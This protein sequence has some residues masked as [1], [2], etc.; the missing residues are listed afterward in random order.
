MRK[1]YSVPGV[2]TREQRKLIASTIRPERRALGMTQL[3]LAEATGLTRRTI[4]AIESGERIPQSDV[5]TRLLRALGITDRTTPVD[6]DVSAIAALLTALLER[7]PPADRVIV[8]RRMIGLLAD[9]IERDNLSAADALLDQ[10]EDRMPP[11]QAT[12]DNIRT[13]GLEPDAG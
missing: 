8:A 5:L 7:V 1:R 10:V 4:T 2:W 6:Q 9:T 13:A 3:E 12:P 11:V